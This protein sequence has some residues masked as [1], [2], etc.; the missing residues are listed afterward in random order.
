VLK[1][2][3]QASYREVGGEVFVVTVDRSFHR[4]AV[5]TAVDLFRLVA[6]GGAHRQALIDHLTTHYEVSDGRAAADVDAFVETLT[7]RQIAVSEASA[8]P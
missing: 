2:H 1:L 7:A 8:A 6:G 4:L 5:P 3:P